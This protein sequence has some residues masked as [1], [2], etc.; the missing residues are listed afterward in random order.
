MAEARRSP[1]IKPVI[2]IDDAKLVRA[3]LDLWTEVTQRGTASGV[4]V[5]IA[6]GGLTMCRKA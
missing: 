2:T 1:F 6:T 5:G 4:I 3:I